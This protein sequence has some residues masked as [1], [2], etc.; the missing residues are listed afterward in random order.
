MI[1]YLLFIK[2]RRRLKYIAFL[3]LFFKRYILLI[4]ICLREHY[5]FTNFILKRGGDHWAY[6]FGRTPFT[7][8]HAFSCWNRVPMT[9]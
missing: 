8:L 2:L 1:S 5:F 4:P 6:A 3:K 9:Q 7:G